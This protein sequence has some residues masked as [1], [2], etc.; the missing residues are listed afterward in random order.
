MIRSGEDES[1]S[2]AFGEHVHLEQLRGSFADWKESV[3]LHAVGL[4]ETLVFAT[5]RQMFLNRVSFIKEKC[6]AKGSPFF[7]AVGLRD[8]APFRCL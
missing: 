3:A 7:E 8:A 1:V 6:L 5:R 4:W 2:L